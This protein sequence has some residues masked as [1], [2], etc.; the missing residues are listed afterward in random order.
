MIDMANDSNLF[1]NEPRPKCLPLYE[2][3][4]MHQ[5]DHRWGT[6]YG[7]TQENMNA[8]ILPQLPES[9]KQNFNTF[10]RTRYWIA[11]EE[12]ANRL[13]HWKFQWLLGFR[14]ITAAMVERTAIFSILPH[15]AVGHSISLMLPDIGGNGRLPL[16]CC[17]LANLNSLC[18]DFVVRTKLTYT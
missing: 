7:A 8:G 11:E 1:I 16:V 12:V 2:A 10:V 4:L 13:E 18:A 14:D 5:F 17:L 6:Y 9:E 3:K 15:A